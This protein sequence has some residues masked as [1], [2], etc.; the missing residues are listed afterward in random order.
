[1]KV[2]TLSMT[3][4]GCTW[5]PTTWKVLKIH[6]QNSGSF[7][8]NIDSKKKLQYSS[9]CGEIWSSA[10]PPQSIDSHIQVFN[11]LKLPYQ[12]LNY[13]KSFI[14]RLSMAVFHRFN[15]KSIWHSIQLDFQL[16]F[17]VHLDSLAKRNW[18]WVFENFFKA[19]NVGFAKKCVRERERNKKNCCLV[20]LKSFSILSP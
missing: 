20:K 15:R 12:S 17:S 18:N 11:R 7:S 3:G 13:K 2:D 8:W 6:S 19:G 5:Q 4:S 1:M 9:V 14:F 10:T 16:L